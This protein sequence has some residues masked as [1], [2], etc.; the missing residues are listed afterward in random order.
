MKIAFI[1]L[2]GD[3]A[4]LAWRLIREGHEVLFYVEDER[5]KDTYKGIFEKGVVVKAWKEAADGAD[6]AFFDQNGLD[7]IWDSLPKSLPKFGGGK[8]ATRVEKDRAFAHGIMEDAGLSAI[9]SLSFK[10]Y[11]E[12]IK[13]VTEHQV[14]HVAKAHGPEILSEHIIISNMDSGEDAAALLDNMD[15]KGLKL[16]QT[17][18]VEEKKIGIECAVTVLLNGRGV[19][20][21]VAFVNF[22]HKRLTA[23]N[24][25]DG[26]GHLTGEMGEV[27]Y[28]V[29]PNQTKLFTDALA[30]VLPRFIK[31][32]Y[33]GFLDISFIANE[34][35]LWPM[36]FTDR[37]GY[38]PIYLMIETITSKLGEMFYA[39]AV[40]QDYKVTVKPHWS[41]GVCVVTPGFPAYEM[42]EKK[43]T[44]MPIFGVTPKNRGHVHLIDA[45]MGKVRKKDGLITAVGIGL[46]MVLTESAPSLSGALRRLYRLANQCN[47]ENPSINNS[48]YRDDIGKRVLAN[49]E[50]I[51]TLGILPKEAF[52]GV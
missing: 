5:Y 52:D 26:M 40:G 44:G 51:V 8:F 21:D 30:K 9:E 22:E 36:E 16:D 18:E 17:I 49:Q 15:A 42:V 41:A 23:G 24:D 13:H 29:K 34:E 50:E 14:M 39:C 38:P 33:V 31:E 10:T 25:G 4:D 20:G 43:S 1:S 2:E 46:P 7:D 27:A 35:G 12:A 6:F 37:P 47:P 19:V 45:E 28:W 11:A 32:G 48:S 3:G